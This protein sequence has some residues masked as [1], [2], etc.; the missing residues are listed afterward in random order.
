MLEKKKTLPAAKHSRVSNNAGRLIVADINI[1]RITERPQ[2]IAGGQEHAISSGQTFLF[3]PF[4]C[5]FPLNS[6]LYAMNST[7]RYA[8]VLGIIS[9]P[10]NSWVGANRMTGI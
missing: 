10:T 6:A 8:H 4:V 2:P 7:A 1:P 9:M 3:L 5:G